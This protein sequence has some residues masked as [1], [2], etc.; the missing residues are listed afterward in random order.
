MS[1]ISWPLPQR[2]RPDTPHPPF[3]PPRLWLSARQRFRRVS[4][5]F[6]LCLTCCL[7]TYVL[8]LQSARHR[9]PQARRRPR[10]GWLEVALHRRGYVLGSAQE[11]F[12]LLTQNAGVATV[13]LGL[14]FLLVLPQKPETARQFTPIERDL[15]VHQMAKEKGS[16]A[17]ADPNAMGVG[18]GF[19]ATLIDPKTWLLMGIL[20]FTYVSAVSAHHAVQ[21][22][23]LADALLTSTPGRCQLVR[24]PDCFDF[25]IHHT[26]FSFPPPLPASPRSCRLSG[27][28]NIHR[29]S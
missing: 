12:R 11:S 8:S 19:L 21:G 18:A 14:L 15:L 10:P 9:D 26:D 16:T 2:D 13:G 20:F 17:A 3:V 1:A 6:F 24:G 7:L 25:R 27:S 22:G 5:P 23:T 28:V 4:F 29:G